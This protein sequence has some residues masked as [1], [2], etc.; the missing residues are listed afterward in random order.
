MGDNKVEIARRRCCLSWAICFKQKM[1]EGCGGEPSQFEF[2]CVLPVLA[3]SV[4][5]GSTQ[6]C[7]M[8]ILSYILDAGAHV[9]QM[10]IILPGSERAVR[11]HSVCRHH[12]A[13]K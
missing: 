11:T 7:A 13:K 12:L 3:M 5:Q 10:T 9:Q 6:R 2:R 4:L 1:S 8:I